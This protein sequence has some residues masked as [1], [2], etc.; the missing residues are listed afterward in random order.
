MAIASKHKKPQSIHHKKRQGLH[1]RRTNHFM[2]T[3]WPYLPM[4]A[5]VG[6]ALA[7]NSIW[8]NSTKNGVLGLATSM[9]ISEL[10]SD[11]NAQRADNG[12]SSLNLNGELDSAAQAKA[13]DMVA[14]NYWSH[15]NPQ[16]VQPWTFITNAGYQYQAAGENLAYGFD[17]SDDTITGWMNSP[18]HRANILDTS[19]KDV[20]FG[21]ANSSNF[22]SSGPETIVVA[23]YA[24]PL[25]AAAPAVT[26][27]ATPVATKPTVSSTPAASA[28]IPTTTT[29]TTTSPTTA[30]PATP[31]PSV[32]ATTK[33]ATSTPTVQL[34]SIPEPP[35]R[36]VA[37]IQLV[38]T[39][40][41]PWSLFALSSIASVGLF[42]IFI[43]HGRSW[44][45][46]V[47]KGEEFAIHHAFLDILLVGLI[48]VSFVL[49]RTA[50]LIR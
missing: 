4:L 38:T 17:S 7:I 39:G 37:R 24:E 41:A 43:K 29:P 8:T 40:N 15:V 28:T 5:I 26:K 46:A 22:Q 45:K 49:T 3:Y 6:V 18:D 25:V 20:G 23:E 31:T 14:Q 34:S 16:G 35:S 12:L 44:Q 1:Q 21:F 13:N 27:P 11:T 10:L 50:G 19:Y 32:I 36:R 48:M 9:S 2:K 30:T 42:A 47:V 33:P